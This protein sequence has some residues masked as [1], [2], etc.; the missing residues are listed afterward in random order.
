MATDRLLTV[1]S[2]VVGALVGYLVWTGA[3]C[4]VILMTP[5][6][7]WAAVA[8]V[9]LAIFSACAVLLARRSKQTWKAAAWWSAPVLPI[10]TS[11]YVLVLL[12]T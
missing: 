9:V 7:F 8:A 11:V 10:L 4:L 12:L 3:V 5:V 6:R 2:A 1:I